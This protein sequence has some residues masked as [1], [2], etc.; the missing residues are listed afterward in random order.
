[1]R[2]DLSQWFSSLSS[3]RRSTS[4]RRMARKSRDARVALG[5]GESL[6]RRSMLAVTV[7][8]GGD[9]ILRITLGDPNDTAAIVRVSSDFY[10]VTGTGYSTTQFSRFVVGAVEV[11]GT[12][13]AFTVSSSGAGDINAGFSVAAGIATT[14]IADTIAVP[15][16]R[17]GVSLSS[18]LTEITASLEIAT[19]NE[20]VLFAGAVRLVGAN[21]QI[22]TGAGAGNVTFQ[23]YVYANATSPGGLAG[24][25]S[26][27]AGT[28]L[29]SFQDTVGENLSPAE[30]SGAL[31]T[32]KVPPVIAGSDYVWSAAPLDNGQFLI[33]GEFTILD[34]VPWSRVAR[35]N[36]DGSLDVS[37]TPPTIDNQVRAVKPLA[38]G[39]TMIGGRFQNIDAGSGSQTWSNVAR[40]NADGTLDTSFRPPVFSQSNSGAPSSSIFSILPLENGQYLVGGNFRYVDTGSGY[41]AWSRV[42]RLNADGTLDTSFVP[43]AFEQEVYSIV[44][45]GDGTYIVAGYFRN[46]DGDDRYRIVARLLPDGSLDETYVPANISG[47]ALAATMAEDGKLLIAGN[48]NQVDGQ[49]RAKV[50]RL[51]ADGSLDTSFVPP[52]FS[53][54]ARDID[55]LDTGKVLVTGEFFSIDGN[56]QRCVARLNADGSLDTSFVPPE[57]SYDAYNTAVGVNGGYLVVGAFSQVNSDSNFKYMAFLTAPENLLNGVRIESA[58]GVT[59]TS[60]FYLEGLGEDGVGVAFDHGIQ[61]DEGVNNVSLTGGGTISRFFTTD[62]QRAGI[63]FAGGST[64]STISGFA[65]YDNNVGILLEGPSVGAAN[66]AG[67]K[68]IDNQVGVYGDAPG[69]E[70]GIFLEGVNATAGNGPRIQGNRVEGNLDVGVLVTGSSYALIDDNLIAGNGGAG[71]RIDGSSFI[72]LDGNEVSRNGELGVA[73]VDGEDVAIRFSIIDNNSADGILFT[74]S[75]GLIEGN[76]IYENGEDGIF[77]EG[78]GTGEDAPNFLVNVLG[79]IVRDNTDDGVHFDNGK[80]VGEDTDVQE[81]IPVSLIAGNTIERNGD[82]GVELSDAQ[83]VYV[84]GPSTIIGGGSGST[85]IFGIPSDINFINLNGNAGVYATGR[86]AALVV[87]NEIDSNGLYGVENDGADSLVVGYPTD[88]LAN[89]IRRNGEAGVYVHGEVDQALVFNNDISENPIGVMLTSVT[90]TLLVGG[91]NDFPGEEETLGN[92]IFDNGEGLRATGSFTRTQ[93]AVF[94]N[95]FENNLTGATLASAQGLLFGVGDG[96]DFSGGNVLQNNNEGLRASGDL[97]GTVVQSNQFFKNSKVGIALQSAKNL[98]V[99]GEGED[100]PNYIS[101]S[102]VGLSASG[103]MTGTEVVFN[104]VAQNVIGIALSKATGMLVGGNAIDHSLKYGISVTGNNAGTQILDNTVTNTGDGPYLGSGIYLNSARNVDIIGNDVDGSSLAGLYATGNTSGTVV[105]GNLFTD[106]RIGMFLE[107]A[108]N[109]V[110]GGL[111]EDEGNTIVGGGDPLLGEY[112]DGIL[113]V[114][115]STG[116]SIAGTDITDASTGVWFRNAQGIDVN[117]TSVEG[118]KFFGFNAS[119]DLTGSKFHDNVVT[120][121]VGIGGGLGHAMHLENAQN[122]QVY[123]NV[124]EDSFGSGLFV[125]GNTAGTTVRNNLFDGNRVGISLINATNAAIGG[126]DPFEKNFV[127]G[128]SDA[129]NGVYRDGIQ[130][131]GTSTGSSITGTEIGDVT[132]GVTLE[133]ATGLTVNATKIEGAQFL[134]VNAQ[135]TLTGTSLQNTTITQTGGLGALGHGIYLANASDLAITTNRVEDSTGGGLYATGTTTGT[136][137]RNNDFEGNRVGIYLV[138]ATDAVIGGFGAGNDNRIVGGGDASKGDFRDG[139]LASGTLTGSSITRTEI[140]KA[141]TGITLSSASGLMITSATVRESQVFGL[142]ASGECVSGVV[143][144]TF[145]LTAGGAGGGAGV[146]LSA[147]RSFVIQ[148]ATISDNVIGLLATG[149]CTASAVRG[150]T[151]SGNTTGVIDDSTG[152]PPLVI[153]PLP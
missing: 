87:A 130:V 149:D 79:N 69:N 73:V 100:A 147:A 137:V 3:A 81:D 54:R 9:D 67:T 26:I 75:S 53:F 20:N 89:T 139:I 134:G 42:A 36:A 15:A 101:G 19:T 34:T 93:A 111:G 22:S 80:F 72:E 5:S 104:Q 21:L 51:N 18:P 121:T 128:G 4:A 29:V 25:L 82:N 40:L 129:A 102:P 37:F 94:G 108:T 114:G 153:D 132:T 11:L 150:T 140:T 28:G 76:E 112:R 16:A 118:S 49:P 43:P 136:V 97:T 1:M 23:S 39:K 144:S 77:I 146:L 71:I 98:T 96:E 92:R 143:S 151:W 125:T 95:L 58:G 27:D 48:F 52:G 99:G 90:G 70:I 13:K 24:T 110:F 68:I 103:T 116:S 106:N 56:P 152:L 142:N 63:R 62:G 47:G 105:Q 126:V 85:P 44:D 66:Y 32:A 84:G 14:T 107:G 119:G 141:A 17:G 127:V 124:G 2:R 65:V 74:R 6:E 83:G 115:T 145:T 122:L 50:A 131:I 60:P 7:D 135:G 10:E 133:N 45:P 78:V 30:V 55:L 8:L 57:F 86:T 123:D 33:G 46:V 38:D 64:N 148:D 59:S 61:I 41:Q 12:G 117:N 35:L 109:A 31:D 88:E 138:D 113:V 120:N 91:P